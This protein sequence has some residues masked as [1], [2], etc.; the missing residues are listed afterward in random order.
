[1][2]PDCPFVSLSAAIACT[3]YSGHFPTCMPV[4]TARRWECRRNNASI[5][6]TN[7]IGC[8]GSALCPA[9][10]AVRSQVP[11]EERTRLVDSA[12]A[13]AAKAGRTRPDP[14]RCHVCRA[15]LPSA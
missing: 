9:C 12:A 1:M 5:R 7:G 13:E 15:A 2:P 8:R 11:A 4:R 14:P 3:P 6:E 10:A